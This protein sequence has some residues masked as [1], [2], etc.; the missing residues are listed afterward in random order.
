[1]FTKATAVTAVCLTLACSVPA[2]AQHTSLSP[3]GPRQI[4]QTLSEADYSYGYSVLPG[5]SIDG[6]E[7]VN[8]YVGWGL[9]YYVLDRYFLRPVAH[10]YA[11]MPQFMQDGVGNF[12]SNIGEINNTVNQLLLGNFAYSATSFARL[13]INS[14]IG[15]LGLFDPASHMGLK[16]QEMSM[17]TVLGRYGVDQ[18]EYL[19]IPFSGPST[20]RNLHASLADDWYYF[21][22]NEPFVTA[23]CY[24][25]HGIHERAQLIS[26]EKFIDDS[27]D[28]YAQMRQI[29]LSY[30]QG[31]VD[32]DSAAKDTKETVDEDFLQE[33]D[34]N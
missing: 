4:Y 3:M 31:L 27:V 33:V 12:F 19:M 30:E 10:G 9:N 21:A 24:L 20:E 2:S 22:L 18:G 28:P 29:Y 32:P 1:M 23:A 8:R 34:E 16:Q 5:N 7:P 6:I 26:Q 11:M 25:I 13:L 14:T 17:N 15:L